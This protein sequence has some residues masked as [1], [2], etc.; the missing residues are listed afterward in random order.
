MATTRSQSHEIEIPADPLAVFNFLLAPKA[1]RG[2]W[3]GQAAIITELDGLW[4]FAWGER[5]NDPDYVTGAR[6]KSF[7][8]PQ[9]V[10][11]AYEYCRSRAGILPFGATMTAEFNMQKISAPKG[12]S[13]CLLRITH[14]GFPH[15]PDGDAFYESCAHG[16]RAALQGIG[17]ALLP[18]PR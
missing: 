4:V 12:Q 6:I 13:A 3:S 9:R 18:K 10:I 14:N 5:E 1:V 17:T 2:R 16:W 8:A 15:G 11:L 7:Q